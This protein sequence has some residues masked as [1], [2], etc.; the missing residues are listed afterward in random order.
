MPKLTGCRIAFMA[1]LAMLVT[2]FHSVSAT[3]ITIQVV[4]DIQVQDI[5]EQGVIQFGVIEAASAV[6]PG[7]AE[8]DIGPAVAGAKKLD[9]SVLDA[10]SPPH[11]THSGSA[12]VR[13]TV[14]QYSGSYM[15]MKTSGPMSDSAAGS[16]D[17]RL[18]R[19]DNDSYPS[20]ATHTNDVGDRDLRRED[21][22]GVT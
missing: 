17:G 16:R 1:I 21:S 8:E 5:F 20:E 4:Q 6:A 3:E 19:F 14:L 13:S 18:R 11:R 10:N 22:W 12:G 15:A 2:G 9:G 7:I